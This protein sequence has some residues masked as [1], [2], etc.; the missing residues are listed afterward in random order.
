MLIEVIGPDGQDRAKILETKELLKNQAKVVRPMIRGEIRLIGLDD[1]VTPEEV[2][3]VVAQ[4]GECSEDEIRTGPIRQMNNGL[5]TIW[6]QCPLNAAL[7]VANLKKIKIGWTLARVDLLDSRPVQ[8]FKC[9]K[10]GHVRLACPS[11]EDFTGLC[12]K[13]GRKGH[14]ANKCNFL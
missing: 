14:L 12:F 3:F 10:Y 6:V 5:Y 7:K 4:N 11:K 8:C 13:C 2:L 9:W 1:S